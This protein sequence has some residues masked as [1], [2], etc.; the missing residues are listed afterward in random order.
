M[1]PTVLGLLLRMLPVL[2]FGSTSFAIDRIVD[3]ENFIGTGSLFN[4][5]AAANDGDVIRI[6]PSLSGK[7][8]LF[9]ADLSI[10]DNNLIIDGSDLPVPVTFDGQDTHVLIRC[11][12]GVSLTCRSII[13]KNGEGI[14]PFTANGVGGGVAGYD[15]NNVGTLTF[16]DCAM[17]NNR[18]S[19]APD[20]DNTGTAG[21][22]G[23]GGAIFALN[24]NL[25]LYNC[26]LTGNK[27]GG[28][29][30]NA[31]AAG[32]GGNGGTGGAIYCFN[33]TVNIVNSSITGNEGG[34]GG[35]SPTA[36]FSGDGG[37]GGG[38]HIVNSTVTIINSTISGNMGGEGPGTSTIG[39][40]GGGIY[41]QSGTLNISNTVVAGNFVGTDA[42][43]S[44]GAGPDISEFGTIN[45]GGN[46]LVGNNDESNATFPDPALPGT[47]NA[48]GDL[49]GNTASPF[50]PKLGLG[51]D[52]KTGAPV[53]I[54]MLG[55]PLIDAGDNAELPMDSQ[56]VDDDLDFGE[57][58]PIDVRDAARISG[59]AIDIGAVEDQVTQAHRVLKASLTNKLK[60]LKKKLKKAKQ[61]RQVT[62]VKKFKKQIKK[63][64]K[65]IRAL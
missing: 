16:I 6:D 24:C 64:T 8:I 29:G 3:N 20:V 48:N 56:D 54:P 30:N 61:K 19:D 28:G 65:Q 63:L 2:L 46:N 34:E 42:G 62:K 15:G 52:P 12:L 17:I 37:N 38:I 53:L 26:I 44:D 49:V 60:K 7:T 10:F 23:T 31:N 55:S 4:A 50:D 58:I 13:F 41:H 21:S 45:T 35:T 47:P 9:T 51:A 36:S 39:G 14:D 5:L 40:S 11:D 1:K 22:G 32:G 43:G 57:L 59:P 33:S 18:G 27:A 25:N